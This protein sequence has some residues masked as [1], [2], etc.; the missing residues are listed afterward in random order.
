MDVTCIRKMASGMCSEIPL[1]GW[2]QSSDK[3]PR[4]FDWYS[5][6]EKLEGVAKI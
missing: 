3:T 6:F 4:H 2:S 1:P 5:L